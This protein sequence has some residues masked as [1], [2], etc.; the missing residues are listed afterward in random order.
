ML[1]LNLCIRFRKTFYKAARAAEYEN[2][3][4]MAM[5]C[6]G[7]V[8]PA[9]DGECEDPMTSNLGRNGSSLCE[10]PDT[11]VENQKR[12]A[13]ESHSKSH[14]ST[15]SSENSLCPAYLNACT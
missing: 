13:N 14:L 11:L 6:H 3:N 9:D 12:S 8:S 5:P 15:S 10:D 4:N 7:V 1:V 2:A